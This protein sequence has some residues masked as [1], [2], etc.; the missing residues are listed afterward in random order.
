MKSMFLVTYSTQGMKGM[1]QGSDR[2]AAVRA[3]TESVGGKFVSIVFTRGKYDAVVTCEIPDQ[4][5]NMGVAMAVRSSGAVTDCDVLEELNMKAVT[6]A[7][8]KA[9]KSYKPPA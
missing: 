8:Q 9:V 3:L 2:E 4:A 1:V 6:A 7:A 5:T